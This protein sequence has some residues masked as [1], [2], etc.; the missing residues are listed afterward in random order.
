M[1]LAMS[2]VQDDM[3]VEAGLDRK[4]VEDRLI[5]MLESEGFDTIVQL[6]YDACLIQYGFA[7]VED[8]RGDFVDEV[9]GRV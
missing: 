3:W 9:I 5:E 8:M 1:K 2:D 4:T 6:V 7:M